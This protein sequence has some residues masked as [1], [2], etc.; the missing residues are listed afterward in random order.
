[1]GPSHIHQT[2]Y[3]SG[4]VSTSSAFMSN[5]K[6]LQLSTS[7][8]T[9]GNVTATAKVFIGGN[10]KK[11]HLLICRL[12]QEAEVVKSLKVEIVTLEADN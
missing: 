3:G 10:L 7:L 12:I 11:P 1:M 9:P 2:L 8:A 4:S 6:S 5:M